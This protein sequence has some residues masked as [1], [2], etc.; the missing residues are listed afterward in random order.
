MDIQ[1]LKDNKLIVFECISGS[2]AYGL[3][4]PHSDTDIKGVFILPK[5]MF[6]SLNYIPQVSNESNDEVYYE[7]RIFFELLIKN[8]PTL[9]EILGT[10]QESI[11]YKHPIFD[12]IKPEIF[13]SKLCKETFAGYAAAQ[14]KKARGLNKKIVNPIAPERK[15]ILDF[16]YVPIKQGANKVEEWLNQLGKVQENC[17]LV[18]IPHMPNVY[19]LF[20]DKS[21]ELGYKGI[22]RRE[23]SNDISLSSVDKNAVPLTVMTFNVDGYTKYCSDYKNYWDWVEQRNNERFQNT[24]SN[25]KNYDA[26]NMMHTFRL[27]EMAEEIAQQKKIIVRRSNRDYLL[28]IRAGEF[29]YENLVAEAENKLA[30]IENLF[31]ESDLLEIP[32]YETVNNLLVSIRMQFYRELSN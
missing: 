21:G 13:L 15:T 7:L 31:I 9:L 23:N 22:M 27:L 5:D 8:N 10:P 4:L 1:F 18:I 24:I 28:K 12:E 11:L 30:T 20:Y 16:C 2:K 26:K 17:G 29:E 6:Y 19:H 3:E 25:G 14:I 32:D